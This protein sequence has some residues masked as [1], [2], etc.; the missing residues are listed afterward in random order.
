MPDADD[1]EA[2]RRMRLSIHEAAHAWAGWRFGRPPAVVS[3]RLGAAHMGITISDRAADHHLSTLIDGRHP[4]DGLDP[5][6]RLFADRQM[7]YVLIGD[8]A[9]DLLGPPRSGR[10]PDPLEARPAWRWNEAGTE[11]L[12]PERRER[13]AVAEA[14]PDG[15]IDDE[16]AFEMAFRLVGELANVYL[17]WPRAEARRLARD[18]ARPIHALAAALRA[19]EV[20]DG[21]DAIA[22]FEAQERS[23]SP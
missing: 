10:L 14:R 15:M 21:A 17:I 20:L 3:I 4:L 6:A 12:S 1:V 22:I 18:H 7:V 5:N 19:S 2:E 23:T 16:I 13:L 11:R 9:A 8:Q